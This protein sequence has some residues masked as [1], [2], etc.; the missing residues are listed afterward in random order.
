MFAFQAILHVQT[1][2][3]FKIICFWQR[4]FFVKQLF[5]SISFLKDA[6]FAR[7]VFPKSCKKSG[8]LFILLWFRSSKTWKKWK[9]SQTCQKNTLFWDPQITLLW[10]RKTIYDFHIFNKLEKVDFSDLRRA[11]VANDIKKSCF[12]QLF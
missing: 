8:F 12:L 9:M 6:I 1:F 10:E 4:L 5:E 7:C 3:V 11:G 2:I